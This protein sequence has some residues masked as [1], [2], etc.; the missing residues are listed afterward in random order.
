MIITEFVRKNLQNC[1][2]MNPQKIL[3][4]AM[5]AV[6]LVCATLSYAQDS[7]LAQLPNVKLKNI[8]GELVTTGQIGQDGKPVIVSFWA[9]WCKPCILE[10][11]TYHGLYS[12][13]Q[14]KYGVTVVAVSIDDSR[15]STKVPAFAKGRNWDFSVLLDVNQEFKRAMNVNNVPH[16]FLVYNGKVVFSHSAYAAGDELEMEEQLQK[17]TGVQ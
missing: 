6:G 2:H 1:S 7:T 17:L 3:F 11:Q 4:I 13:W 5:V 16:T 10:L 8:N 12:N 14:E 15:N 9:T